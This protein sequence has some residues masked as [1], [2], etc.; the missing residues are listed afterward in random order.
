LSLAVRVLSTAERSQGTATSLFILIAISFV[1]LGAYVI[2]YMR[3]VQ[4]FATR[5]RLGRRDYLGR[6]KT[7]PA[8]DLAEVRFQKI[9][10]GGGSVPRRAYL[11]IGRDHRLLMRMEPNFWRDEDV[12]R[13][14]GTIGVP[15]REGPTQKLKDFAAEFPDGVPRWIPRSRAQLWVFTLLLVG[16]IL[17]VTVLI[18][19]FGRVI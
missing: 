10:W 11:F 16:L 2:A 19:I 4:L 9:D 8:H 6:T 13:L 18:G 7:W 15:V 17:L 12:R 5:T 3:N 14:A 1:L